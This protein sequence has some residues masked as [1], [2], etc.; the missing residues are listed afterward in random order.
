MAVDPNYFGVVNFAFPVGTGDSGGGGEV[1]YGDFDHS[2][3]EI[4][5][6]LLVDLEL[7]IL[8]SSWNGVDKTSWIMSCNES[9]PNPDRVITTIDTEG[10]DTG[11]FQWNGDA[12]GFCGIQLQVRSD[13]FQQGF[14]KSNTVYQT[15]SKGVYDVTVT[16]E[17]AQYRVHSV[18]PATDIIPLGNESPTS[19]RQL[20]TLNWVASIARLL[21]E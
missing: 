21:P 7:G 4:I 19:K 13:T 12:Q 14:R 6:Q 8:P 1:V 15:L 16:I 2:P 11:F 20:F 5:R 10:E 9:P 17:D 18:T 3:A